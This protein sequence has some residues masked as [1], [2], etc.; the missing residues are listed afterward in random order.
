MRKFVNFSESI[1]GLVYRRP[2]WLLYVDDHRKGIKETQ[3]R[4]VLVA[5]LLEIYFF[6]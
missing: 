4:N 1:N 2:L 6:I 5:H 3:F